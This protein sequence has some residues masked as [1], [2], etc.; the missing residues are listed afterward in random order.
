M[1]V[2]DQSASVLEMDK[3]Q[4]VAAMIHLERC[5]RIC[6]QS[7]DFM[8]DDSYEKFLRMLIEH[9]HE[10]VLEHVSVTVKI[11]CSRGT[12]HQLVRHRLAAYSQ[13]STRYCNYSQGRFGSSV[14]FI[15]PP[16]LRPAHGQG[17]LEPYYTWL[18]AMK[19]SE[20]TYLKLIDLGLK[21]EVARGVLPQDLKTEMVVTMN[22]RSWRHV[23]KVR[24]ANAAQRDVR[25]LM[26]MIHS[27]LVELFPPIFSD[28]IPE[29]TK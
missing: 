6:Y 3:S 21:P 4:A 1:R 16:G 29:E 20:Q 15:M 26:K 22:L 7:E 2:I 24:L 9:G 19:A 13:E 5:G 18:D 12:S 17:S 27:Q 10:S 25:E 8:K 14:T 11:V 28:I 23:L